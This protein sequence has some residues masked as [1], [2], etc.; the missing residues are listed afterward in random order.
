MLISHNLTTVAELQQQ[1]HR[2]EALLN[3]RISGAEDITRLQNCV[4]SS[5]LL[6]TGDIASL[7]QTIVK[8]FTAFSPS[9]Q[10]SLL[11][12]THLTPDELRAL[13]RTELF[14][15]SPPPSEATGFTSTSL[16]A[17]HD[18][19]SL[20]SNILLQALCSTTTLCSSGS[21]SELLHRPSTNLLILWYTPGLTS[22]FC[23]R[24]LSGTA[25]TE[26]SSRYFTPYES[27]RLY[28]H[29]NDADDPSLGQQ[30]H[31]SSPSNPDR[32]HRGPSPAYQPPSPLRGQST[33]PKAFLDGE[34]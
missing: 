14:R 16:S 20:R 9:P 13:I 30:R 26:S 6:L 17:Y 32:K 15:F 28:N 29:P 8:E 5:P 1:C 23:R 27:N 21:S 25:R 33:F 19:P 10:Q 31:S 24:R 3:R 12:E 22:R 11:T 34:K 18:V 4:A 7:I 2:M